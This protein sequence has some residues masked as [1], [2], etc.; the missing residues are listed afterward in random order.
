MPTWP[1]CRW[2]AG[3]SR[4]PSSALGVGSPALPSEIPTRIP[5]RASPPNDRIRGLVVRDPLV[6][7]LPEAGRNPRQLAPVKPHAAATRTDVDRNSR[8]AYLRQRSGTTRTSHR[9]LLSRIIASTGS[10]R[11][12]VG[13]RGPS[14]L[15]RVPPA[16]AARTP[17][18]VGAHG[19]RRRSSRFP[20]GPARS[21]DSRHRCPRRHRRGSVREAKRRI[22]DSPCSRR[23][24]GQVRQ[25]KRPFV[26][27]NHEGSRSEGLIP[28]EEAGPPYRRPC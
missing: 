6:L 11:S 8:P 2:R 9:H 16:P 17:F 18:P 27:M 12:A 23:L 1:A 5:E 25:I 4:T 10:T 22:A 19:E 15:R 13:G 3:R 28:L 24:S 20:P 21:P 26:A 7:Q 14:A